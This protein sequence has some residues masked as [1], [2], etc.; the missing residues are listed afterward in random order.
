MAKFIVTL[1]QHTPLIHFQ[2]DQKGA[3][4]RASEVKPKLDKFLR[5]CVF[6]GEFEEYKHYL[7][8]YN[9]EKIKK[10]FKEKEAF[11]YKLR[12]IADMSK[13]KKLDIEGSM[14]SLYFANMGNRN[15][16]IKSVFTEED[17][18]LEFF[19][20]H[21]N[22]K[23]KIYE[24]IESF[25]AINNFGAR[26]SKGF[27][28]F[29]VESPRSEINKTIEKA[30][31]YNEISKYL[32]IQY[33]KES[34]YDIMADISIIY[35]LI[36]SGI[37]YPD[38]RKEYDAKKRKKKINFNKKGNNQSYHK[39][40]LFK[41]MIDN[42]I[43][44]E[45]RFIKEKFFE[46]NCRVEDDK[47]PKRYVRAML[48]V[49]DGI[50]FKDNIRC[51]NINYRSDIDRFQSPILFKVIQNKLFIIPR[52][53]PGEMFRKK[54][55]FCES[56]NKSRKDDKNG[57]N[58]KIIYTPSCDEF[59]LQEF[60]CE[61]AEYFNKE[62]KTSKVKNIFEDRLKEAKKREIQIVRW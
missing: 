39:G 19:T 22:L 37:N 61:F 51:G 33:D 4:L 42:G 7:I 11:D 58:R 56:I 59:D 46:P 16:E 50:S 8:G 15:H 14:K 30:C 43:G 47:K 49:C 20:L 13:I 24:N 57:M 17:V 10:D 29:Y 12:I 60:L 3:I 54:F 18:V 48:G 28:S 32:Y 44:N 1:K 34:Y 27:G 9:S 40:F 35:S 26:Q 62:I 36:K 38:Y 2:W 5:E 6:K 21:E 52:K 23:D 41:F 31:F 45:K 53:I 55:E 25:L